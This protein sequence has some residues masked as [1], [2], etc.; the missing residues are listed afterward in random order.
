M[1]YLF[2]EFD[3]SAL[4]PEGVII[5]VVGYVT[6]FLAL[7]ILYMVFTYLSKSL[8]YTIIH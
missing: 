8:N 7:L 2:I 3:F 1:K 5:A 6:V 4:F